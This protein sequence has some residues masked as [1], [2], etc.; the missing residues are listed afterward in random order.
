MHGCMCVCVCVCVCVRVCV[1]ACVCVCVCMCVC[2]FTW[3]W[4]WL[5]VH[6]CSHAHDHLCMCTVCTCANTHECVS[7]FVH[8]SDC[9]CAF[10]SYTFFQCILYRSNPTSDLN[11]IP[12]YFTVVVYPVLEILLIGAAIQV[13]VA[14]SYKMVQAILMTFVST[15]EV[16]HTTHTLCILW[17][18]GL[19]VNFLL[20]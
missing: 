14:P 3:T 4:L 6:A 11:F 15:N 7:M 13:L 16:P 9:V 18:S 8:A 17:Y 19:E 10:T 1:C 12:Y 5:C 20:V 2:M